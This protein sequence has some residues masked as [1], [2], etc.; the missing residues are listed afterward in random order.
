MKSFSAMFLI[1]FWRV[2]LDTAVATE[3]DVL[4]AISLANS[5]L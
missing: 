5:S 4:L 3:N 2:V 1:S